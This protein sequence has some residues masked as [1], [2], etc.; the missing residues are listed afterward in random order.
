MTMKSASAPRRLYTRAGYTLLL[1]KGKLFGVHT[2]KCALNAKEPVTVEE[3]P[4]VKG[5]SAVKVTQ[6]VNDPVL[7]S[8][9][10]SE[11]WRNV[12]LKRQVKAPGDQPAAPPAGEPAAS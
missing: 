6:F 1:W 3:L 8:Q 12:T 2:D 9:S 11:T 7:G 10:V 5:R 4:K